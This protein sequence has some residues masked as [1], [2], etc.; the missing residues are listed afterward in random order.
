MIANPLDYEIIDAHTHPFLDF[1][2]GC[3]GPYGKPETMEEFDFDPT[4]GM[5]ICPIN[6]FDPSIENGLLTVRMT[7]DK[8]EACTVQVALRCA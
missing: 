3:I 6:S 7:D 5:P 1:K 4:M 2:M 8:D